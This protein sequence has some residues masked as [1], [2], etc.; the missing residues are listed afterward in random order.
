VPVLSAAQCDQFL[1]RGFVLVEEVFDRAVANECCG[2]VWDA[3]GRHALGWSSPDHP[4]TWRDNFVHLQYGFHGGPFSHA[5]TPRFRSALDELLGA[6]RWTWNESSGWWPVLFPGFAAG[7][8]AGELG[9]H[10]DSDDRSPT[11]RVP[12]KAVVALWYFSDVGSGDGGT[13]VLPGSHLE[14]ARLLAEVEPGSLN[15]ERI[16]PRMPR[17]TADNDIVEITGRAGSVLFAHPFVVHASNCN[18]GGRVRFAC[19]PHVDLFGPLQ[20]ERATDEQS[21]V[22]QAVARAL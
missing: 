3:V 16:P 19:N 22:E 12:E 20:L 14:I 13:A 11:L 21:L 7:R 4:V 1:E 6:D 5:V 18:T 17:P 15:D 10:V 2:V 8:S 9:W